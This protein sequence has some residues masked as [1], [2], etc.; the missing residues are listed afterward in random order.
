MIS[1]AITE[2]A[3]CLRDLGR[4]D[5]AESSYEDGIRRDEKLGDRRGAAV[6]RGQL[7]TVRLKQKRY[8][9]ALESY[10]EALRIF[11][12]LGEPGSVAVLWH[13]IGMAHLRAEQFEQAEQA[14]RQ[15]LAIWVQQ[16]DRAREAAGWAVFMVR[17]DGW[18]RP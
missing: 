3:D 11:E 12:L 10:R 13:Q 9:E 17:W 7:G 15:S 4:Y 1:G 8:R 6:G 5:E 16:Q 18:K 14:Y 2:A